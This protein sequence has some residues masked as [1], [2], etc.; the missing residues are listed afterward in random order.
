MFKKK[1]S[2]TRYKRKRSDQM[3]ELQVSS[4]RIML[5]Q[6]LKVLRS[7]LKISLVVGILGY[8]IFYLY[9]L[10]KNHFLT[11]DEFALHQLKLETNGFMNEAEV[12]EIAGIDSSG[13][14]FAFDAEDAEKRLI[15][16]PEIVSASVRRE[17][18]HD[19]RVV[20]NER[21]PVAWLACRS[22]GVAGRNTHSGRLTDAKGVTFKC[23][24]K[25]WEVAKNLPVIDIGKAEPHE[26][27]LG[28]K[29]QHKDAERALAL[30]L[31]INES[32][33][34]A[35]WV[36]RI[37]VKN[38]YSLEVTSNDNLTATFGMYEHERQLADLQAARR[39]A[40]ETNRSLEWINL[41]PKHNIPG[42]FKIEAPSEEEELTRAND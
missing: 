16:R 32:T 25:L 8:G 28:K 7:V 39:H 9:Q 31:L 33:E 36:K 12:A 2:N 21:V 26:V 20:L 30:L 41:L 13:T 11:S 24:G 34:G 4:P 5:H 42:K 6:T 14:I 3:L 15:E 1:K 22:L 18:P 10:S 27:E 19:V 35:W 23:Q 38:F 17:Y 29:M 40:E 37:E